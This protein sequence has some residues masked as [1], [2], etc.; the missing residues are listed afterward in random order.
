MKAEIPS[1]VNVWCTGV[2]CALR[3]SN[4][5]SAVTVRWEPRN[6]KRHLREAELVPRGDLKIMKRSK[7]P[8]G[9]A[10]TADLS[11]LLDD[12]LSNAYTR[13]DCASRGLTE[14]RAE[15]FAE[16]QASLLV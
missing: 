2:T 1:A 16:L 6:V 9:R 5:S 3:I 14:L 10:N 15:P 4:R 11:I 8:I 12:G 13:R 7:A